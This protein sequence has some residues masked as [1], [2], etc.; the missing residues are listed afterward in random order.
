MWSHF[1]FFSNWPFIFCLF[2]SGIV[3][4]E[5]GWDDTTREESSTATNPLAS[6]SSLSLTL[7][8]YTPS[9]PEQRE[10]GPPPPPPL[11]RGG[12]VRAPLSLSLYPLPNVRGGGG[13]TSPGDA[14]ATCNPQY[15]NMLHYPSTKTTPTKYYRKGKNQKQKRFRLFDSVLCVVIVGKKTK[16]LK[17]HPHPPS[18]TGS[19]VS[20]RFPPAIH[21]APPTQNMKFIFFSSF[22]LYQKKNV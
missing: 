14:H 1:T 18:T 12:F 9:L 11:G 2:C 17:S 15:S 13:A 6:S 7:S 8:L 20:W 4:E 3:W 5:S 16:K 21:P 22:L 10:R 19:C